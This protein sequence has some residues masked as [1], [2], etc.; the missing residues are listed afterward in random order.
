MKTSHNG[1]KYT[2]YFLKSPFLLGTEATQ[3]LSRKYLALNGVVSVTFI[4]KTN[5]FKIIGNFRSQRYAIESYKLFTNYLRE[6]VDLAEQ[7]ENSN[8]SPRPLY[9]QTNCLKL[10]AGNFVEQYL[11]YIDRLQRTKK[12]PLPVDP[13]KVTKPASL[14]QKTFVQ[15][16]WS[17]KILKTTVKHVFIRPDGKNVLQLLAA[18][19][20]AEFNFPAEAD[21]VDLR[22][23]NEESMQRLLERIDELEQT[24]AGKIV[25]LYEYNLLYPGLI[26]NAEIKFV[27]LKVQQL[28]YSVFQNVSRPLPLGFDLGKSYTLRLVK[29]DDKLKKHRPCKIKVR[30]IT[31]SPSDEKGFRIFQSSQ[32]KPEVLV[33]AKSIL[34]SKKPVSTNPAPTKK[35]T[36]SRQQKQ[37]FCVEIPLKPRIINRKSTILGEKK[38]ENRAVGLNSQKASLQA[39]QPSSEKPPRRSFLP[40]KPPKV[41]ESPEVEDEE[42]VQRKATSYLAY[43]KS[44]EKAAALSQPSENATLL[45]PK[46]VSVDDTAQPRTAPVARVG[47]PISSHAIRDSPIK[48][49]FAMLKE[50]EEI[51]S[52]T[53][54]S[55]IGGLDGISLKD[56][57]KRL[58]QKAVTDRSLKLSFRNSPNFSLT[59]HNA[60]DQPRDMDKYIEEVNDWNL[61]KIHVYLAKCAHLLQ[62]FKGDIEF[63][64]HFGKTIYTGLDSAV[65]QGY[66]T[67]KNLIK[68]LDLK[69]A[70]FFDSLT[71]R[72]DDIDVFLNKQVDISGRRA[73]ALIKSDN[74]IANTS[75]RITVRILDDNNSKRSFTIYANS[76]LQ[77]VHYLE[78]VQMVGTCNLNVAL[79]F[80]DAQLRFN[81]YRQ[82]KLPVLDSL[83]ESFRLK[84][85]D[86]G[87]RKLTF[88]ISPNIVVESVERVCEVAVAF[89]EEL[90]PNKTNFELK[91]SMVEAL[92]P[93]VSSEAN[94]THVLL[95]GSIN[96]VRYKIRVCSPFMQGEFRKNKTLKRK[97]AADWEIANDSFLGAGSHYGTTDLYALILIL[98]KQLDGVGCAEL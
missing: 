30:P 77:D 42:F 15:K 9:F 31:S 38:V 52:A 87:N 3:T 56:S 54:D 46:P 72:V 92:S 13:G 11:A 23:Q 71:K 1:H 26:K 66:Y 5:T 40:P 47:T 27:S 78:N 12:S 58:I 10:N 7:D 2:T 86:N 84:K 98:T 48:E 44:I 37:T 49:N 70:V 8:T 79:T 80:W 14:P 82:I 6:A 39:K 36:K 64:A 57:P 28:F 94:E 93:V 60:C 90:L 35:Q 59:L 85:G 22:T 4:E 17:P 91:V 83:I 41:A 74:L 50:Q 81:T 73:R 69:Q 95:D 96:T 55:I 18:E 97:R 61:K 53:D 67:Y 68:S 43:Q 21:R 20:K 88:S 33:P 24:L 89:N 45:T 62:F 19:E 34:E 32:P 16:S 75:I 63:A 65:H 29:F 51:A 25:W 76:E